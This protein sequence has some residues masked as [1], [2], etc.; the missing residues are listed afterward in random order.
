MQFTPEHA[1]ALDQILTWR[2][3][4][5]HFHTDPVPEP[6]LDEL[7]QAM[8]WAPS[9]GN[10]RPWRVVRVDDPATRARL[11]ANY[12]SARDAG[13]EVYDGDDLALY[14]QLKLSGMA[15]APVQLAVFTDTDPQAGR[16]LG[17]QTMPETLAYST[18]VAIHTLWLA[19]HVR[20]L[21]VGWVSVLDPQAVT[22][23]LDVPAHWQFTAYL[24]LG[25]PAYED[26]RP[27]LER[28]GWQANTPTPWTR[29]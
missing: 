7:A 27:E 6:V 19:A 5:R 3:D 24:C 20:N 10:S 25:Y 18:V 11:L 23:T 17:R 13:A 28:R 12:E 14:K 2:R 26:D 21:G 22:D 15:E 1:Q 29:R 9:V 4:I 16:G 8:E